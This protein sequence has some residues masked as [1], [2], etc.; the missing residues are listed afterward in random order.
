YPGL[1]ISPAWRP[2]SNELAVTLSKDGNPN[3]YLISSSGGVIQKLVQGFSI[4]VSPGW[5]PDGKRLAYVSDV[6]GNPQIYV[7]DVSSGQ[8]RRIT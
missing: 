6:T 5:S 1:N 3:I 8:K 2:G 7:F 4:N